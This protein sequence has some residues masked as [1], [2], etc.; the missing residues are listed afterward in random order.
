M[1][2]DKKFSTTVY[3]EP[4]QHTALME[5]SKKNDVP[6]A[7][8]IRRGV[9]LAIDYYEEREELIEEGTDAPAEDPPME[10][11]NDG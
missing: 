9:K 8:M 7:V 6:M 3:L 1:S 10:D 2:R 5:L 11:Q 4:G